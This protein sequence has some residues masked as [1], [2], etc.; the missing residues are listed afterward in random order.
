MPGLVNTGI[1]AGAGEGNRTLVVS[2]GSNSKFFANQRESTKFCPAISEDES[3]RLEQALCVELFGPGF[4]RRQ[5]VRLTE[6]EQNICNAA[7][8][9]FTGIGKDSFY[10]NEHLADEKT[11]L[12]FETVRA[13]E[14]RNYRNQQSYRKEDNPA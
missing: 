2:L 11:V 3:T 13:Y 4:S 5:K 1:L 14:A 10:L 12:D 6:H 7:I 8:L 9:P